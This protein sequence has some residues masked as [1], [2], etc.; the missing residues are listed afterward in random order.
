M[1]DGTFSQAEIDEILEKTGFNSDGKLNNKD[2][3]KPDGLSKKNGAAIPVTGLIGRGFG[4][5]K[6]GQGR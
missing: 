3:S 5:E 2:E 6:D 4:F 1:S